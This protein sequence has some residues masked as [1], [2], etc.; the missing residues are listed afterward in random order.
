MTHLLET[1]QSFQDVEGES[2][3]SPSR[4]AI[5]TDEQAKKGYASSGYLPEEDSARLKHPDYKKLTQSQEGWLSSRKWNRKQ[6]QKQK[7]SLNANT[8]IKWRKRLKQKPLGAI[9]VRTTPTPSIPSGRAG[10]DLADRLPDSMDWH[11]RPW[12]LGDYQQRGLTFR[13]RALRGLG[14]V[15]RLACHII[16]HRLLSRGTSSHQTH[17]RLGVEVDYLVRTSWL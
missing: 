2:S 15:S 4:P 5:R 17:S 8:M 1:E 12:L 3:L 13:G 9:F 14:R 11:C 16:P 10:R 6:P 7:P